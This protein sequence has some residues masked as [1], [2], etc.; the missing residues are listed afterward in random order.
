[1]INR[2]EPPLSSV[3]SRSG[4]PNKIVTGCRLLIHIHACRRERRGTTT[5]TALVYLLMATVAWCANVDLLWENRGQ[6]VSARLLVCDRRGGECRCGD[7]C[8]R[9]ELSRHFKYV[10]L[11]RPRSRCEDGRHAVG[12]PA[13][14][15][16]LV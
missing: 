8:G 5:L 15:S 3:T 14:G 6:S 10:P 2:T 1:M 11:V 13:H 7:G 16:G 4:M 12:G 9:C